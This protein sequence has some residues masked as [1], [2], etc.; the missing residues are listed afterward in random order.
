M[1][2]LSSKTQCMVH[3]AT[4]AAS[5]LPAHALHLFTSLAQHTN[6]TNIPQQQQPHLMHA[7]LHMPPSEPLQLLASL[8][9]QAA[10]G[11]RHRQAA[12][13]SQPHGQ[14]RE[15]AP[16]SKEAGKQAM[17]NSRTLGR[18]AMILGDNKKKQRWQRWQRY[19]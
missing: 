15:A 14:P 4:A 16:A 19:A 10:W 11:D 8:A 6:I 9:K 13:V 5:C 2:Q 17:V 3:C 12:P 1:Q 18:Q 7:C